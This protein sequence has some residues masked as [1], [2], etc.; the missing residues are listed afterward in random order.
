MLFMIKEICKLVNHKAYF[1]SKKYI[2]SKKTEE[3]NRGK[4][5]WISVKTG[6]K[7]V[8]GM[9]GKI[10]CIWHYFFVKSIVI[11]GIL[12]YNQ[13]TIRGIPKNF[14]VVCHYRRAVQEEQKMKRTCIVLMAVCLV[15]LAGLQGEAAEKHYELIE[16]VYQVKEGDTLDGVAREYMARNTYG[17]REIREFTSGIKELNDWLLQ[18]DIRPGDTLHINY[19]IKK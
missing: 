11:G 4:Y 10:F 12:L 17:P 14:H 15:G 13:E 6:E 9:G 8:W 5:T 3:N 19:W 2:T 7:A 18:R 16:T 1:S